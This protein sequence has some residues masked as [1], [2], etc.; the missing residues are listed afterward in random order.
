MEAVMNNDDYKLKTKRYLAWVSV[1]SAIG[2]AVAV[3]IMESLGKIS[4]P[5]LASSA[6]GFLSTATGVILGFYFAKKIKEE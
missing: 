3:L 4:C 2:A 5:Q 1:W 6:L